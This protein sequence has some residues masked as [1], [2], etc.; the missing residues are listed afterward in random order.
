MDKNGIRNKKLV[1]VNHKVVDD[2]EGKMLPIIQFK[3]VKFQ[4]PSRKK[5]KAD[6]DKSSKNSEEKKAEEKE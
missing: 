6:K 3:N 1:D 2:G 4:Y 5:I